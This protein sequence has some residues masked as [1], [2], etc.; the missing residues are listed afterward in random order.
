MEKENYKD[1]IIKE[2][3]K[4]GGF[5]TTKT[6]AKIL[7][8]TS[9]RIT[10]MINEGKLKKWKDPTGKTLI[11]FAEVIQLTE[12]HKPRKGKKR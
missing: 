3:P 7:D 5:V 11:S 4:A 12:T 8:L 6:A 1:W 10:Q 2:W 9:P